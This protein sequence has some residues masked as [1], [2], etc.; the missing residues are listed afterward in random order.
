MRKHGRASGQHEYEHWPPPQPAFRIDV[1]SE[2]TFMNWQTFLTVRLTSRIPAM[3]PMP[4]RRLYLVDHA[5]RVTEKVEGWRSPEA[6]CMPTCAGT[7]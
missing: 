3:M 7:E 5:L 6:D 1:R 2:F 4:K